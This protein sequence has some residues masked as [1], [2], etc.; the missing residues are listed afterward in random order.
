M[1]VW[2]E[3]FLESSKLPV[4]GATEAQLK[5]IDRPVCMDRGKRRYSLAGHCTQ[6]LSTMSSYNSLRGRIWWKRPDNDLL[7]EWDQKEWGGRGAA[8]RRDFHR[9]PANTLE[10]INYHEFANPPG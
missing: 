4:V 3:R 2:R 10:G 7:P 1:T 8:H 6:S 5:A 9:I